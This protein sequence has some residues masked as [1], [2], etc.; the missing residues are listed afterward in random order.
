MGAEAI[1]EL[2]GQIDLAEEVSVC[3]KRFLRPTLKPKSKAVQ[4]LEA[5]RGLLAVGNDPKWMIMSVLPVLPPDLRPLVPL[6]G[7]RLPPQT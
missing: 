7:G 5:F 4:T 6:D 3:A 1:Q 2:L